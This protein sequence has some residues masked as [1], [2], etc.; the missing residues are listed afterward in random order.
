[1]KGSDG[2]ELPETR[3]G[4]RWIAIGLL[5]FLPCVLLAPVLGGQCLVP[6]AYQRA[7]LPWGEPLPEGLSWN[8]LMADAV[9]QYYPWRHFAHTALREGEVPLWNPHQL[10]GMPFLA[11][12]QSAVL[13]P[14]NVLF[15]LLPVGYAFGV[16]A[17]LHLMAAG[18][19]TYGFGRRALGLS[20][21]GACLA[22]VAYQLSGFL[23]AWTP[24]TAAMN[25]MA[26]IPGLLLATYGVLE[27]PR[28]GRIA[29]LGAAAGAAVLAGHLQ[30]AY[31]GFLIAL[32][33]GLT[34]VA[35]RLRLR[36][37]REALAGAGALLAGVG[38]GLAVSAA[39][40]LPTME[41]ASVNHRP[42]EK[43]GEALEFALRWSM[44][45]EFGPLMAGLFS[46]A[47]FGNP[48][49]GTWV[50]FPQNYA[51]ICGVVGIATAALA[52]VG[53]AV[54]RSRDRWF[55]LAVALVAAFVALGTPV[56]SLLY[57]ALPG[58]SRFA[59]LPRIL[60]L[61]SLAVALLAGMGLDALAVARGD[62]SARRVAGVTG[63][64]AC[65]VMALAVA[66]SARSVF[67]VLPV[68]RDL[69]LPDLMTFGL[70]LAVALVGILGCLRVADP[71][72]LIVVVAAELLLTGYGYNLAAPAER[73]F[74]EPPVIAAA[75]GAVA[76]PGRVMT[77][78]RE[79]DFLGPD[80]AALPPNMATVFGLRDVQGY[81][82]LMPRWAK[83]GAFVAGGPPSP[84]I[85]G[86]MVLMGEP[87]LDGL[88]PHGLA[89][90]G[91]ALFIAGR[92][93]A[94]EL[95]RR[96]L[97]VPVGGVEATVFLAPNVAPKP[98]PTH[99]GPNRMTVEPCLSD[100]PAL[101]R[102]TYA[103]GWRVRD[104]SGALVAYGLDKSTGF[105][106]LPEERREERLT[107]SYEPSS[108]GVGGFVSG[109]AASALSGCLAF[110]WMARRRR[111]V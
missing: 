87:G 2:R 17:V 106:R 11:N 97:C 25:T 100:G 12:G 68:A 34:A 59:G 10:C 6:A 54:S 76:G 29:L 22:G 43:T 18:L 8:A 109:V 74:D 42:A 26:W 73:V 81:D 38:I 32:A 83:H 82:S 7:L 15:W 51:E 60:C 96:G 90:R 103:P 37:A 102:E 79:W 4:S 64:V 55:L 91:V 16:G 92:A 108:F 21:S 44:M 48:S 72:I 47:P 31:Y 46:M 98:V 19:F 13:Y 99:D 69:V 101:I 52:A 41:L 85:N 94:A 49:R 30:F 70:I 88:D 50:L 39:Q 93:M 53:V 14:P 33:Y 57:W 5:L 110:A 1:M 9:L 28:A 104:A 107:A 89:E 86:N 78:T 20:R 84:A 36:Q 63:A 95:E 35:I 77:L 75:R 27:A 24:M 58:F 3:G 62:P 45:G 40:L 66:W 111:S 56:A 67:T 105:I 65:G 71:R 80:E 61:W 23:V